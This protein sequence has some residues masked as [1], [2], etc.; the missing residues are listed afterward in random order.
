V[1]DEPERRSSTEPAPFLSWTAIYIVV[2]A[3]LAVEIAAFV[4]IRWIYR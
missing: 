3:S 4:A 1:P 2:A